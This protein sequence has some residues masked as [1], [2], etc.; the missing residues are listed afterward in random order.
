MLVGLSRSLA[1]LLLLL[2]CLA[3]HSCLQATEEV[4]PWQSG[5]R[6]AE[7]NS[8]SKFEAIP[9][10]F[11]VWAWTTPRGMEALYEQNFKGTLREWVEESRRQ[12]LDTKAFLKERI[13]ELAREM[14][15][16]YKAWFPAWHPD[17]YPLLTITSLV[18]GYR[19]NEIAPPHRGVE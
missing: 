17:D 4:Y 12:E 14:A 15:P 9:I 1:G 3:L 7:N 16:F 11:R 5:F 18:N 8:R 2:S 13:A 19:Q 6:L 10:W